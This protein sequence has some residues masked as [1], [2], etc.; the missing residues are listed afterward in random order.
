MQRK[1]T[2]RQEHIKLP[3]DGARLYVVRHLVKNFVFLHNNPSYLILELVWL[4]YLLN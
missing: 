2:L 4:F 3:V 1:H